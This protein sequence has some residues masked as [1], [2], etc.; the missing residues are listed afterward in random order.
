MVVALEKVVVDASDGGGPFLV[1]ERVAVRPRP[2]SLLAGRFDAG[3]VEVVGPRVRAVVEGGEIK[4]LRYRLP[5]G[6]G[7]SGGPPVASLSIT[8]ARVDAAVDKLRVVARA[9]DADISAEDE[10]AFEIALRVGETAVT[11][12]RPFPGRPDEDAVDDDVICRAEAR[13]RVQGQSLLVRRL[14]LQGSADF[15]PDPDTRPSCTLGPRDWRAVEVRLGALRVDLPQEAR[16]AV[17]AQPARVTGRVH[18][19]LP[20]ALVHRFK[21]MAHATGSITADVEIDYDGI[22]PLPR[23]DGHVL[24][25]YAGVDGKVFGQ[26]IDLDV[27]VR[28]L[29]GQRHERRGALGGRGGDHPVGHDQAVRGGRPHRDEPHRHRGARAHVPAPRPGRAPA[30]ARG[31]VAGE[32]ALRLHEG[33]P[34]SALHRGAAHRADARLRDLRP[35]RGRPLPRPH[36]GREGGDGALLVRRQRARPVALQ[37]PRRRHLQRQHR[38]AA[39]AIAPLHDGDAGHP[40]HVGQPAQ[41]H[42]HRRPRGVQGGS[43]GDLAAGGHPHRWHDLPPRDGAGGLRAPEGRRRHQDHRFPVRRPPGEGVHGARHRRG[44]GALRLRAAGARSLRRAPQAWEEPR[45]LGAGAARLQRGG[46]RDRRRRRRQHRCARARGAGSPRGLPLRQGSALRRHR[47]HGPR[48]GAGA[49]RARRAG[50]SLRRRAARRAG[51]H[52]PGGRG[53]ARRALRRG[54]ARRRPALGRPARGHGGDARRSALG[55][56][57]QGGGVDPPRRDGAPR[58]LRQRA[59]RRERAAGRAD[60]RAGVAARG[61][62]RLRQARRGHRVARGRDRRH[63]LGPHVRR[64]RQRLAAA[65]RAGLARA[66]AP[67][68]RDERHAAASPPAGDARVPQRQGGGVQPG[69]VRPRRFRRGRRRRRVALRRPA[70]A[71]R[72]ARQPPAQEGDRARP[73]H[74]PRARPRHHRQPR[75]RRRLHRGRVLRRA[76]GHA[77]RPAHAP[78]RAPA[79]PRHAGDRRAPRRAR[80]PLGR[81]PRQDGAHRARRR[82]AQGRRLQGPDPIGLRLR[83]DA[84][85]RR[86]REPRDHR[87]RARLPPRPRAGRPRPARGGH[88]LRRARRRH[89]QGEPEHRRPGLLAALRGR[90]RAAQGRAPAQGLPRRPERRR[91]RA[92][93]RR[94]RR[95]DHEGGGAHR[96]RDARA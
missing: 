73:H 69:R 84:R 11:R 59:R 56:A 67:P 28:R 58:G 46:D 68:G 24:A 17:G 2:F 25:E 80:R 22:A 96:R 14:S 54:L 89:A 82:P 21:D 60:R 3:D 52:G 19:K 74:R 37:V 95:A 38:D 20:T 27:A 40:H 49:L 92:G 93:H 7:P 16:G 5:E 86:I 35:A 12:V 78:R 75:A 8:D 26:R 65:H 13:V 83:R 10:G 66:L 77:R 94:R 72:P 44:G 85:P 88:P 71:G 15:D 91:G 34:R 1:A 32:G 62:R 50:G 48:Q 90:R 79:R 47:G 39:I 57:A 42:R 41:H 55:D 6:G 4:N 81:P 43:G 61:A 36:D 30:G 53:P 63:A 70:P 64:R 51:Q 87:A 31:V 76:L 29:Q 23:V 18:A 45:P 9:L 33:L